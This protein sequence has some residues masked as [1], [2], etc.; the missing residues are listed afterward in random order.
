MF[1][2]QKLIRRF[3]LLALILAPIA[4]NDA[5]ADGWGCDT[6]LRSHPVAGLQFQALAHNRAMEKVV[7]EYMLIWQGQQIQAA[8][9]A[10]L[11]G[12]PLDTSCFYDRTDWNAI[13]AMIPPEY[14]AMSR[15]E[16]RPIYLEMQDYPNQRSPRQA[17]A[18]YCVAVGAL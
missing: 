8:C 18:D 10:A 5:Q 6:S 14:F 11:Q 3:S 17:A 16:L 13:R 1:K 7:I 4:A 2:A 15:E 9:D 12:E